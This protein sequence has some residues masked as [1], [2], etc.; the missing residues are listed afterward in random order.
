[1]VISR[2]PKR[3]ERKQVVDDPKRSAKI[4]KPTESVSA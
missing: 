4:K 3:T 2:S 1:V